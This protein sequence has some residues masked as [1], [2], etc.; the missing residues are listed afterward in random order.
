MDHETSSTPPKHSSGAAKTPSFFGR[1]A[2]ID[3]LHSQLSDPSGKAIMIVGPAGMGKSA[4]VKRF[5]TEAEANPQPRC[6]AVSYTLT[7]DDPTLFQLSLM[8]SDAEAALRHTAQFLGGGNQSKKQLH[9]LFK[10]LP[11]GEALLELFDSLRTQTERHPRTEFVELLEHLSRE[12]PHD[13]RAVFYMDAEKALPTSSA[14]TWR[15]ITQ[16]LPEKIVLIFTQRPDDMLATSNDFLALPNVVRIPKAGLHKLSQEDITDLADW[17]SRETGIEQETLLSALAR[18]DGHPYAMTAAI[19]L[20]R[21]GLTIKELPTDPTPERIAQAQWDRVKEAHGPDAMRLFKAHAVLDVPVDDKLICAVSDLNAETH[22]SLLANRFL[23][24][25]LRHEGDRTTVYHAIL[26]DTI[27]GQLDSE[28]AQMYHERAAREFRAL[29]TSSRG[30]QSA[31]DPTASSRLW[32]HVEKTEGA[33]EAAQVFVTDCVDPLLSLGLLDSVE[34]ATNQFLLHVQHESTLEASLL[35]ILGTVMEIRG[36]L[37]RAEEMFREALKIDEKADYQEGMA[38]GYG[39]L[40]LVML[41]RDNLEGA[42]EMFQKSLKIHK[43]IGRTEGI[44]STYSNLGTVQRNRGD[45]DGAERMHQ[46]ALKLERRLG[47]QGGIATNLSNLGTIE[48]RRERF[49]ESE[50]MFREALQIWQKLSHLEGLASAYGCLGNLFY[51]RDDFARAK[52]MYQQSLDIDVKLGRIEGIAS[53]FSNLG[54]VMKASGDSEGAREFWTKALDL[55]RR[56]GAKQ[57]AIKT[58]AQLD[59]LSAE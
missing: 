4:L 45:L 29:L 18:Y 33:E 38:N 28:S 10:L 35:G 49:D 12:M 54:V 7:G 31:P 16:N 57:R 58:Q 44:A 22:E 3:A 41:M 39:R 6:R 20:L 46:I 14:D 55:Y 30:Q 19:Q 2:E 23:A 48:F 26:R 32:H 59:E 11:K 36:E 50:K 17:G 56:I 47:R 5:I 34:D 52:E 13:S 42:E 43:A 8:I 37:H 9:A 21:E 40:G 15:L 25:L 51:A 1:R 53:S 24:S 27:I